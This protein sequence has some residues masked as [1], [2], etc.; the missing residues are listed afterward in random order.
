MP[1]YRKIACEDAVK[2]NAAA[3]NPPPADDEEDTDL[4]GV[5]TTC[6]SDVNA[7]GN[8]VIDNN[9][10]AEECMQVEQAR[11][12][13][14]TKPSSPE[15]IVGGNLNESCEPDVADPN[16]KQSKTSRFTGVSYNKRDKCYDSRISIDGKQY[17]LGTYHN[18][19]DAA[20]AYDE[21]CKVL[22]GRRLQRVNFSSHQSYIEARS[23]ELQ[24]VGDGTKEADSAHKVYEKIRHRID[25]IS[26][27]LSSTT[28]VDSKSVSIDNTT[29]STHHNSKLG[30]TPELHSTKRGN[31]C[32]SA[33]TTVIGDVKK[34]RKRQHKSKRRGDR[35]L[36]TM[37]ELNEMT[38]MLTKKW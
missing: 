32:T 29:T 13:I 4:R 8:D 19:A 12:V 37:L 18:Q 27:K 22:G 24:E 10:S 31:E 9:H 3:V 7:V 28:A 25:A 16:T 30:S 33:P 17:P 34:T 36:N 5:E 14:S 26:S 11:E 1:S 21:Y 2:A 20:M 23:Q 35:K 38:D 6:S 15:P